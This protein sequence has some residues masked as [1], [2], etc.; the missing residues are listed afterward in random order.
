MID[1]PLL[2]QVLH[3]NVLLFNVAYEVALLCET[4]MAKAV[5][6]PKAAN[7]WTARIIPL[8]LIGIAG[9]ATWVFIVL[10]CGEQT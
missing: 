5:F 8:V 9:Y 6:D 3:N 2:D 4:L 1:S 7:I 10:L